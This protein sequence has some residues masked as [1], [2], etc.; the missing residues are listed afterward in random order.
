MRSV[1]SLWQITSPSL[2][3]EGKQVVN[4][5]SQPGWKKDAGNMVVWGASVAIEKDQQQGQNVAQLWEQ[6]S[7]LPDQSKSKDRQ[8]QLSLEA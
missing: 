5:G 4:L 2:L 8:T 7:A 1:P 3:F 6:L